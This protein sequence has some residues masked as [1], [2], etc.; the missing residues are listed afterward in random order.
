MKTKSE[1]IDL[2]FEELNKEKVEYAVLRGYLNKTDF[3]NGKDVDIFV[4]KKHKKKYEK[5][6]FGLNYKT[7]K[8]NDNV[9]PH[10]QYFCFSNEGLLKIDTVFGLHFRKKLLKYKKKI[11]FL[12]DTT[13][14]GTLKVFKPELSL[15]LFIL[16]LVFDKANVVSDNN[17]ARLKEYVSLIEFNGA[18]LNL[19]LPNYIVSYVKSMLAEH[20]NSSN[21]DVDIS[22]NL[23]KEYLK[24]MRLNGFYLLL[25]KIKGTHLYLRNKYRRREI[26]FIGIDGSGKSSSLEYIS[27]YLGEQSSSQ[28]MGFREMETKYG[29]L[30]LSNDPIKPRIKRFYYIYKEMYFRLKKV[31]K[32]NK[33][34]ILLDRYPWEAYDNSFG[35]YKIIYWFFFK[36]LFPK[37]KCGMYLYCD[38]NV[39]LSRKD[40]IIDKEQFVKNKNNFD[41]TYMNN[42]KF[43]SV[44]TGIV[45]YEKTLELFCDMILNNGMY[46]LLI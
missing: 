41:N 25:K 12:R 3:Y 36:L 1:L 24:R 46:E 2:L 27:T 33:K 22:S 38:V 34:L 21:H 16:H 44:D 10:K 11:D 29:K 43:V 6:M 13:N 23:K 5:I 19:I 30:Y 31:R 15:T 42:K 39:S 8:I 28:Y 17:K 7:P 32:S 40:D 26:A 14:Y 37:P 4:N 35:K 20:F 45:S 18:Q 9:Y